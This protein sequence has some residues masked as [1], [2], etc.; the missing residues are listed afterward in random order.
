M[1]F[2]SPAWLLLLIVVAALLVGYLAIQLRRTRYVAR[3]SNV[4][5]LGSIAPRRP[6]WRRHLTF[7][8]L[9]LPPLFWAG[10]AIVGRMAAGMVGPMALNADR[11]S[12]KTPA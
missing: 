3:F 11:S 4:E 5:L 6:G 10:N 1:H 9:L 7:A 12:A 2:L 8:L